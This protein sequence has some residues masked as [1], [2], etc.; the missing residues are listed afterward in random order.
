MDI[1]KIGKN[2]VKAKRRL[3]E[4]SLAS[5]QNIRDALGRYWYEINPTSSLGGVL[6]NLIPVVDFDQWYENALPK[7][8]GMVGSS[9]LQ[10]P[11]ELEQRVALQY[12]LVHRMATGEIEVENF[13]H[14]FTYVGNSNN[15]NIDAFYERVLVSFHND[16]CEIFEPLLEEETTEELNAQETA[17]CEAHYVAPSRISELKNLPSGD[18]DLTRIIQYC[19]EIDSSYI[20]SNFLAVAALTRA[21]IDHVPPIFE[22]DRFSKVTS[23]YSGTRSFK[24]SMKNLDTSARKIG[25]AHL[26]TQIRSS[27]VLPTSVQVD[28][29]N[30]LDVL[31]SEIVRILK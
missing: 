19:I 6:K 30:E 27:E 5:H 17:M 25:D 22:F 16:I 20:N 14:T 24:E 7:K 4:V 9:H 10:W 15:D 31:L 3:E 29:K 2:L 11:F 21:L 18:F 23:N 28:F 26:H 12:E 8:G 13:S 1:E